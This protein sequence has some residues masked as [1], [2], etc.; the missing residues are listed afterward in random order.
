MI[1]SE[2]SETAA[3]PK[4]EIILLAVAVAFFA[5]TGSLWAFFLGE[6][7]ILK[8]I[9][10]AT[11]ALVAAL[12]FMEPLFGLCL[13]VFLMPTETLM[14][15]PSADPTAVGS[16]FTIVKGVGIVTFLSFFVYPRRERGRPWFDRQ[17]M[18]ILAF[19]CWSGL[20]VLWSHTLIPALHFLATMTQIA[21]FWVLMRGLVRTRGALRTVS[22]SFLAGTLLAV[23]A[24]IA[25]PRWSI[26]PR[27]IY[28]R[29]NPN[30][31]ARDIVISLILLMYFIPK[32]RPSRRAIGIAV[33]VMLVFSLALTQ[34]RACWAAAAIC[35]PIL[36]LRRGGVRSAGALVGMTFGAIVLLGMGVFAARLGITPRL[37]QARGRSM[38]VPAVIRGSRAEIWRAG[39]SIAWAHPVL[40]VGAGNFIRHMP[41]AVE[42]MEYFSHPHARLA[43]HN[44]FIDAFAELGVIGLALLAAVLIECFRGL[45]GQP[46][47]TE[48]MLAWSLLLFATIRMI[49]ATSHYQKSIWF[50]LVLSQIVIARGIFRPEIEEALADET[51]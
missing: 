15:V 44:S 48:K 20:S 3:E 24:S 38:F 10:I 32:W 29:G 50:A 46:P 8:G 11:A 1:G 26:G 27:M 51:D 45:K 49:F 36:F 30:H 19:A 12:I 28:A 33:G 16:S 42:R 35:L 41:E 43:A 21:F 37:L 14:A 13:F 4:P 2:L 40:G 23:A 34:S 9:A 47:G 39:L 17:T 25:F 31:L 22:I 5:I 6:M 7:L 18:L